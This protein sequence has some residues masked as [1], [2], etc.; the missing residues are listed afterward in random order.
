[1]DTPV[2]LHGTKNI[3]CKQRIVESTYPIVKSTIELNTRKEDIYVLKI[4]KSFYGEAGR[5][6]QHKIV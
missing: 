5:A 2:K 3:S 4:I 6:W 1:L